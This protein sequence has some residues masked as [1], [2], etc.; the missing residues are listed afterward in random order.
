MYFYLQE[1]DS[2]VKADKLFRFKIGGGKVIKVKYNVYLERY[3]HCDKH[4][5]LRLYI[6]LIGR[7]GIR[8]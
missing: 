5:S 6:L 4:Y 7:L 8:V 3:K 1:F 2:N